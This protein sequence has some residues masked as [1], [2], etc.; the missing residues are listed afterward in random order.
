M[1]TVLASWF[2]LGIATIALALYRKLLAK[3]EDTNI[4]LTHGGGAVVESQLTLAG[5]LSTIDRWGKALTVVT[6]V[7][8][9]GIA[10]YYIYEALL[11]VPV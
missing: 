2:A 1:T 5:K 11:A 3:N 6:F 8:G 7:T 9:F 10:A 4:H